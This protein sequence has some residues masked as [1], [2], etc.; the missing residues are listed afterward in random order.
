[1]EEQIIEI[2]QKNF[3]FMNEKFQEMNE[4]FDKM[5]SKFESKIDA[6]DKKFENKIDAL[7]K[8]FGNKIDVLDKKFENKID[9]L[10]KKFDFKF[11]FIQ[12]ELKQIKEK[13]V[14]HDKK[15]EDYGMNK[16][17]ALFEGYQTNYELCKKLQEKTD[18]MQE[19][20]SINSLKISILED[21]IN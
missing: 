3:N 6:L 15:F 11:E 20:V 8:K 5:E 17:P 14:E 18:K 2:M 16:I 1:M 4:R 12:K 19:Q 21:N 13:L 9:V 7:D 10:D